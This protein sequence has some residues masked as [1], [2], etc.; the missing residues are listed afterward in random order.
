MSDTVVFNK[1]GTYT[2]GGDVEEIDVQAGLKERSASPTGSSRSAATV[3]GFHDTVEA[4][5]VKPG[6][7]NLNALRASAGRASSSVSR[8]TLP[9]SGES[10]FNEVNKVEKEKP[11][12]MPMWGKEKA[13]EL[14]AAVRELTEEP[15]LAP[16]PE[17]ETPV[18]EELAPEAV[19]EPAAPEDTA[20][21]D[22]DESDPAPA[23][24]PAQE[25]AQ[26]EPFKL[27]SITGRPTSE[28]P[29]APADTEASAPTIVAEH[30]GN[31]FNIVP[32]SEFISQLNLDE[33]TLA[34]WC[35][36]CV[37]ASV[38]AP[39]ILFYPSFNPDVRFYNYFQG[40]TPQWFGVVIGCGDSLAIAEIQSKSMVIQDSSGKASNSGDSVSVNEVP[41]VFY[42][43]R[44]HQTR[45]V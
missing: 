36:N 35:K 32:L 4:P 23:P 21:A 11:E 22:V 43:E 28:E 27:S 33:G 3:P 37:R 20:V 12:E 18:P 26:V 13:D 45:K 8:T 7:F 30:S 19:E 2:R 5:R 1:D 41:M 14:S 6:T 10:K 31:G 34:R 42:E 24:E 38:T 9:D 25:R 15:A 29:V 40:R 17:L 44:L 39:S 16:A